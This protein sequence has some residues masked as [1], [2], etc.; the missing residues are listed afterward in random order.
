L[1]KQKNKAHNVLSDFAS[2]KK[3]VAKSEET[4]VNFLVLFIFSFPK[5]P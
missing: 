2:F 5:T 3:F 4:K 1:P